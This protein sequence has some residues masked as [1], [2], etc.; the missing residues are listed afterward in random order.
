MYIGNLMLLA[1]N[2][3]LIGFWV[4]LL[5]VPYRYLAVVV[6]VICV[7]GAYS[8]KNAVFDVAV[9]I[10]FGVLG[11][12]MRKGGFP[13]APMVLAMILGR[14][15]ERSFLRSLQIS[16]ADLGIFIQKPISA[17]LL[18][19]AALVLMTPGA[20]WLWSRRRAAQQGE[21]RRS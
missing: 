4:R 21:L 14:I 15:L 13:A 11:Y 2:L 18:C 19:V 20:R 17:T 5:R 12:L 10:V 9:M 3:P 16:A 7:I 8:I 6:V 1:L